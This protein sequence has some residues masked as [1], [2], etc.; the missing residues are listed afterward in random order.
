MVIPKRNW[1]PQRPG[2]VPQHPCSAWLGSPPSRDLQAHESLTIRPHCFFAVVRDLGRRRRLW[3]MAGL[4]KAMYAVGF[5]IRETGQALDRLGCR[6]QGNYLFH[7]QSKLHCLSQFPHRSAPWN[8]RPLWPD[9][10]AHSDRR[11]DFVFPKRS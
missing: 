4:G 6:L 8:R 3:E 11:V 5:W 1:K 10:C 2:P 7:E 9:S